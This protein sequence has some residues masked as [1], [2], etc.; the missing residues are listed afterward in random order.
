MRAI[1]CGYYGKGNGGDEALLA[2]LLQMLP[3]GVTPIV[4]SGNPV[5][6]NQ[7]YGVAARDRMNAFQ[8]LEALRTSDALIWGGGSLIQDATSIASPFYYGG[9]MGIAQ[10]MGLKTVAWAQG[11]GPLKREITRKLSQRCFAGCTGVSVRDKGSATLLADWQIPFTLAPI[12]CGLWRIPPCRACGI[13]RAQSC[14][15]FAFSLYT[16]SRPFV[17]LNSSFS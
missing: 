17:N 6:T 2:S 12:P 9:L 8:V 5:E 15:L 16:N 3:D 7:R 4:L 10:R 1:L 14:C 11:I 13:Y